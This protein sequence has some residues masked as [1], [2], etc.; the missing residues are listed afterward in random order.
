MK[1][2]LFLTVL[3]TAALGF[4]SCDDEFAYEDTLV[5]E[6]GLY[7]G[8]NTGADFGSEAYDFFDSIFTS[9][10]NFGKYSVQAT[11]NTLEEWYANGD[12]Q[13]TQLIED[14]KSQAQSKYQSLLDI[15][16][17]QDHGL[18]NYKRSGMYFFVARDLRKDINDYVAKID[19]DD[20]KY[21]GGSQRDTTEQ[22][23][24]SAT[25][26]DSVTVE[27]DGVEAGVFATRNHFKVCTPTGMVYTGNP[28]IT[29]VSVS[30]NNVKSKN[31]IKFEFSCV[32]DTLQRL[33][34]NY[35]SDWYI[36][37]FLDVTD[38]TSTPLENEFAAYTPIKLTTNP[39]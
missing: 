26:H 20:F 2:V 39:Y 22:I 9:W 24:V 10:E 25:E 13:I 38:G 3:A 30:Y 17:L 37:T 32:E 27:Y 31:E 7:P 6:Y 19:F 12:K 33:V 1:K 8:Y 4:V 16:T 35:G 23:I 18:G 14:A 21:I 36:L 11:G 29:K 15:A 5:Y 34:S 28:F